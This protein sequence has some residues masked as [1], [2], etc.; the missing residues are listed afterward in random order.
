MAIRCRKCVFK[1][2]EGNKY[3]CNNCS[4]IMDMSGAK[5][6]ENYF[7]QAFIYSMNI[8]SKERLRDRLKQMVKPMTEVYEEYKI[9]DGGYIL[10]TAFLKEKKDIKIYQILDTGEK[11]VENS[12]IL[13][14]AL[15]HELN[16]L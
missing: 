2:I 7:E 15:I 13:D 6:A 16:E 4:E 8:A 3:P 14:K 9:L 12:V 1:D 10:L 11:L 5:S